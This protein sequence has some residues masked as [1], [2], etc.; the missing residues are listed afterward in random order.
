[1]SNGL[2]TGL[3][4]VGSGGGEDADGVTCVCVWLCACEEG[5][6][7]TCWKEQ[8]VAARSLGSYKHIFIYPHSAED[9]WCGGCIAV[10]DLAAEC[11]RCTPPHHCVT[12]WPD[13]RV[14]WLHHFYCP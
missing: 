7:G 1:M 3:E 10:C 12:D 2:R 11:C 14:L 9:G 5:E 4:G 6:G 13:G 8:L